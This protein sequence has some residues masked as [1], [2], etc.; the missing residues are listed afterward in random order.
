MP[1]ALTVQ[2]TVREMRALHSSASLFS[3]W[4]TELCP[5]WEDHIE[6]DGAV[7]ALTSGILALE[8]TLMLA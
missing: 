1:D 8:A 2:L 5:D 3:Q 6:P 4:V 7:P